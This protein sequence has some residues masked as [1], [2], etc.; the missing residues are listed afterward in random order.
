MLTVLSGLLVSASVQIFSRSREIADE[1]QYAAA[2][3]VTMGL[4][5]CVLGANVYGTAIFLL[6]KQK[7][8]LRISRKEYRGAIQGW[9]KLWPQRERAVMCITYSLP[10]MLVT[11]AVYIVAASSVTTVRRKHVHPI[12]VF[13][14]L[15]EV[16]SV[17]LCVCVHILCIYTFTH[18]ISYP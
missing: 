4:S 16:R 2:A 7:A 11:A 17:I 8:S 9:H 10:G 14:C 1:S 6:Q 3:D 15:P 5:S 12:F 13:C 18:S